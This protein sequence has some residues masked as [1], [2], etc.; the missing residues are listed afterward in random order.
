VE[1]GNS[2]EQ[3]PS[4]TDTYLGYKFPFSCMPSKLDASEGEGRGWEG[5]E[6]DGGGKGESERGRGG[7]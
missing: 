6:E 4:M 5:E 2:G 3:P 1:G 7:G